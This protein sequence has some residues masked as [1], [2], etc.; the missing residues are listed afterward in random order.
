M[1]R[2]DSKRQSILPRLRRDENGNFAIMT[3]LM[4]PAA[5]FAVGMTVDF[6]YALDV[7]NDMQSSIDAAALAASSAM[8][9]SGKTY[10]VTQAQTEAKQLLITQLGQS[11]ANSGNKDLASQLTTNTTVTV[12]PVASNDATIYTATATTRI[13]IPL[14]PMTALFAGNNITVSASGSSK[15]SKPKRTGLSMYLALDRS[16]SMSFITDEK[17]KGTSTCDNYTSTSWPNPDKS[18]SGC[19]IRKIQALKTAANSLFTAFETSDPTSTLVRIGAVSYTHETQTEQAL[20]WGTTKAKTYVNALPAKPEGGTDSSGAMD[21]AYKALKSS[22]T[23]EST[24]HTGAGNTSFKR[25][26]LL[27]TDGEMTGYSNAW[28]STLD[29]KTRDTCALAKKD[30]IIIYSVA[31]MAPDKGKSLL[32]ACATDASSYYEATNMAS[33]IKAF[34][35]IAVKATKNSVLLTH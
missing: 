11:L 30:G 32:A 31:F 16:G 29:Q 17:D 33:L 24:K 9:S 15:S 14:S 4:L 18:I 10:T 5:I 27:M 23:T 12:T 21:I 1:M 3:A 6:I 19:R 34:Q 22:N 2:V 25:Y 35:D 7:R 28:N 20:E 26:I 13:T 8:I